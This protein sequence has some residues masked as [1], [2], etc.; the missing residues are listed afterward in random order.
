M[1]RELQIRYRLLHRSMALAAAL[2][3]GG[4]GTDTSHDPADVRT[5]AMSSAASDRAVTTTEAREKGSLLLR[6][7]PPQATDA[8]I[9]G[10]WLEDHYVWLEGEHA[11]GKLSVFMVGE[12]ITNSQFQLL[13]QEAARLGYH[14]IVLTYPNSWNIRTVC[15]LSPDAT[16][17]ENV[18]REI[19]DGIDRTT[20][21]TVTA[22]DSIENRLTKLLRFLATWYPD[23]KWS[24]FLDDDS[25]GRDTPNW[26][27]IAVGG[28]SF[29]GMQAAMIGKLR[30]VKRVVIF[31][32]TNDGVGGAP[33]NW[34][35]PGETS[36][37]RYFGL[38]HWQDSMID[39][40]V[41]NWKAL[42][43]LAFGDFVRVENGTPPY[44]GTHALDT[45]LLP[46]SGSYANA[47]GSVVRDL[48]TP[49]AADGTPA[50]RDA[51]R[52]MLGAQEEG[53]EGGQGE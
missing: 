50:L 52:Y 4:C 11:K 31:G 28:F 16:C 19:I 20:L 12:S 44:G 6:M 51:W 18:R 29:G 34:V 23:E 32:A 26:S 27:H 3:I 36:P 48:F 41:A 21:I 43:L 1:T 2:A 49:L 53:D 40:G 9:G 35:A 25:P 15:A 14:M 38:L 8:A 33:G 7:V 13:P 47:H 10:S 45:D 39:Q 5:P 37:E 22:A 42:G 46:R 24:R 17:Q 30:K